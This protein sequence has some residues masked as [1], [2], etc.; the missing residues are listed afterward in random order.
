MVVKHEKSGFFFTVLTPSW[1]GYLARLPGT[2]EMGKNSCCLR[3]GRTILRFCIFQCCGSGMFIPDPG[4]Q[5]LDPGSWIQ[6]QQQK[7]QMKKNCC[8]TVLFLSPQISQNWKL[9]YFW[10]AEE[11]NLGKFSMIFYPKIVTKLSKIWVWDPGSEEHGFFPI[12][13]FSFLSLKILPID[14]INFCW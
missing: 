12:I 11:K 10:N 4:S 5:I 14:V 1:E 8:H 2:K 3:L 7:R 6:K 9:L 13:R